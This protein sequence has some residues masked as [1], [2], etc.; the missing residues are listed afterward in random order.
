MSCLVYFIIVSLMAVTLASASTIVPRGPQTNA[1]CTSDYDWTDN[2]SGLSP[3]LLASYLLGSC[4]TGD[5]GVWALPADSHYNPP[6]VGTMSSTPCSCSW[7]VYNLLSA[8]TVCQ[9]NVNSVLSWAYYKAE[10]PDD[11]LSTT[12]FYPYDKGYELPEPASIPYWATQNHDS[13]ELA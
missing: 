6:N 8:C 5:Y 10:C 3:C 1:T 7:S 9:G 2:E 12:T 11:D 4:L 13:A